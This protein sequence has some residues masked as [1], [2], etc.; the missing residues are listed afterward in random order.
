M[1]LAEDIPQAAPRFQ[2]AE[3][4]I[5]WASGRQE[6]YE[7]FDG[8][9][10]LM[11]G[12][13]PNHARLSRNL[14]TTLAGRLGTGPCEAFGGD[15]A[16]ILGPQRV[17]FADVSVSCDGVSGLGAER[18][19]AI[20][21]VLSPSTAAYDLGDK[22]SAYRRMPSLRH[23]VL[24]SQDKIRVE[25]FHRGAPDADFVLTELDSADLRLVLNAI[26][27]EILVSE[28]YAQVTFVA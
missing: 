21:E 12:G 11:T 25:H 24:V 22:A 16:I 26:G 18:P 3:D 23:L 1:S 28:I 6:R 17:V 4:F 13:S 9:A 19:V 2:S 5:T 8:A 10:R 14:L 7:L 15:L 20:V 27:V